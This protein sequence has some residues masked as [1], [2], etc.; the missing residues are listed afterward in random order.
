VCGVII[1]FIILAAIISAL[2]H[3]SAGWGIGIAVVGLIVAGSLQAKYGKTK[4]VGKTGIMF[5]NVCPACRKHNKGKATICRFCG[6]PLVVARQHRPAT[7][8][9]QTNAQA[10]KLCP[11]C[12][13]TVLL[14]ARRCR[15][16]G[17]VFPDD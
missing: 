6:A 5:T 13:E 7:P 3:V 2:L 8:V 9:P 15:Y 12:A 16:C 1:A 11:D 17:Y 10:T 14:A 4:R